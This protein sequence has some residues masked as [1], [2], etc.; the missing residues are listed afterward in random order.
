MTAAKL[1]N[2]PDKTFVKVV[3]TD[4]A[5]KDVKN[6]A[7]ARGKGHDLVGIHMVAETFDSSASAPVFERGV[8]SERI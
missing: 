8:S 2:I 6:K 5:G 1:V 7:V 3:I 4:E